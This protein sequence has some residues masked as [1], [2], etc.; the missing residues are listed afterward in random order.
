MFTT[1]ISTMMSFVSNS[2]SSFPGIYCFGAFAAIVVAVNYV[3]VCTFMPTVLVVHEL[4]F[5]TDESWACC[6]RKKRNPSKEPKPVDADERRPIDI[7]LEEKCFRAI[8]RFRVIILV[9]FFILQSIFLTF[10]ARLEPDPNEPLILPP[11]DPVQAFNN[12]FSEYFTQYVDPYQITNHITIGIDGIDRTGID[13]TVPEDLGKAIFTDVSFNS[14]QEQQFLEQLCSDAETGERYDDLEGRMVNF[15][16]TITLQCFM[17]QIRNSIYEDKYYEI[18]MNDDGREAYFDSWYALVESS[19][20]N[21]VRLTESLFVDATNINSGSDLST[22]VSKCYENDGPWTTRKFPIADPYNGTEYSGVCFFLVF[23]KWLDSDMSPSDK[24]YAP[25]ETNYDHYKEYIWAETRETDDEYSGEQYLNFF[26]F[27]IELT[28]GTK[29]NYEE[30]LEVYDNWEAW[31]ENWKNNVEG[32][33]T[34]YKGYDCDVSDDCVPD[35]YVAIPDSWYSSIM[36]T[37]KIIW[38][39]F[40]MQSVILAEC[41]SG[42]FLALAFAYFVIVFATGNW[43]LST[44]AIIVILGLVIDVMGFTV[45]LG[46][47]L[48]VVEA[49]IYIMV[50]GMSVD[51]VVH[52]AEAY[53]HSGESLR[54][55]AAR[56]MLGIVG[57]SVISGAVSTCGGIVFLI[58]SYNQFFFKFGLNIFFLMVMASLYALVGFTAAMASFGPQ[59]A[60]GN[61]TVCYYWC[62]SL[63]NKEYTSKM[64]RL[65]A[66]LNDADHGMDSLEE[67]PKS[68]HD[69]LIAMRQATITKSKSLVGGAEDDDL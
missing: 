30:A 68:K 58:F 4:Y 67:A 62:R 54:I 45:M 12:K 42:I 7:F 15:D 20:N 47:R 39:Y 21:Y 63:C 17:I 57:I 6:Q 65:T 66:E 3:A 49:I 56:R 36:F 23:W 34:N 22:Y 29:T 44:Y 35:D 55:H 41:Y 48:G 37:D 33:T 14:P 64:E 50:V 46:Y 31:L 69:K 27:T 61:T 11:T 40:I 25:G 9:G 1:S 28:I 52:L 38:T 5:W 26:E 19:G 2:I 51:Y 24:N 8:Y 32:A 18:F 16:V 10:M 53:L 60:Q 59:G 43:I 13:E